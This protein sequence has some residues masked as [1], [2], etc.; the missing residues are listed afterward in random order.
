MA[1]RGRPKG[2][3]KTGGR[4]KGTPNKFTKD[5]REAI[6]EGARAA[7]GGGKEGLV[8]YFKARA[9][10]ES[11]RVR[12]S[13]LQLAGRCLPKDINLKTEDETV[14]SITKVYAGQKIVKAKPQ[15]KVENVH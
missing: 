12:A 5:L 9:E 15:P 3:P 11:D 14:V 10:D 7:G 13:F 1:T 8:N 6:I 2:L 4:Q